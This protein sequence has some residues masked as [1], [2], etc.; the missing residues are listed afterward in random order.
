MLHFQS[1]YFAIY[2][3]FWLFG[4]LNHEFSGFVPIKFR[5]GAEQ[6]DEIPAVDTVKFGNETGVD[7]DQL[8]LVGLFVELSEFV[9]PGGGI[10]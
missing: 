10:T 2:D 3:C 8:G 6:C 1:K 4:S 9:S 7:E 5:N